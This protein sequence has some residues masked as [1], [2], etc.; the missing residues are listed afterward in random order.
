MAYG[1]TGGKVTFSR[2][3]QARQ[4]EPEH[5]EVELTFSAPEGEEF[6]EF[7]L[8]TLMATAKVQVYE[9]LCI[10]QAPEP[11]APSRPQRR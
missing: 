6:N 9:T 10:D 7:D 4:F 1:I 11:V 3:R 5:A 8:T 2:T